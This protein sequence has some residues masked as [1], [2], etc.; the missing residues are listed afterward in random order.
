MTQEE[1]EQMNVWAEKEKKRYEISKKIGGI[2]GAGNYTA[3]HYRWD[4]YK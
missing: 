3:L 4:S 1:K 2:D